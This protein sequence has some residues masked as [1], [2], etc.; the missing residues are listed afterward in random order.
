MYYIS[1]FRCCSLKC[2]T[3]L[4]SISKHSTDALPLLKAHLPGARSQRRENLFAIARER[5]APSAQLRNCQTADRSELPSLA[6]SASCKHKKQHRDVCYVSH[7]GI[8][9][10]LAH[11]CL[12]GPGKWCRSILWRRHERLHATAR[13][14]TRTSGIVESRGCSRLLLVKCVAEADE[15]VD[16]EAD[17][18]RCRSRC[19]CRDADEGAAAEAI[20]KA[21]EVMAV[22]EAVAESLAV[23][24]SVATAESVAEAMSAQFPMCV[25]D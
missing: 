2:L 10:R 13:K 5:Q 18:R 24:E 6:R 11:V 8:I 23:A 25:G 7:V 19:R 4:V 1:T 17:E 20:A 15:G 9:G 14:R 21:A 12:P 22:A 3:S 16:A